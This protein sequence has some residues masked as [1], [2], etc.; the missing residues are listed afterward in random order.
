MNTPLPTNSFLYQTHSCHLDYPEL[1][2]ESSR[3]NTLGLKTI[4]NI[5][6]TDTNTNEKLKN[7][8]KLGSAAISTGRDFDKALSFIQK[9]QEAS[10]SLELIHKNINKKKRYNQENLDQISQLNYQLNRTIQ[11]IKNLR[12]K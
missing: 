5:V 12:N 8:T 4:K 10:D 1:K 3:L 7:K 11:D 2:K 6:I 9:F